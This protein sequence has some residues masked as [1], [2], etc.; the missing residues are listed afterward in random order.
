MRESDIQAQILRYLNSR[1]DVYAWRNQSGATRVQG[2]FL[3][4]G[5]PGSADIL[6][7]WAPGRFL[8]VEVKAERGVL[9]PGQ[10]AWGARVQRY[11]GL[12]VVARSVA[13]VVQALTPP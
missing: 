7:V 6:G 10:R 12:Y 8:A 3:R 9:S 1:P 5:C 2:R 4:F 11:G 13:D